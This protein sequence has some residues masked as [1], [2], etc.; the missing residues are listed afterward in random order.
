MLRSYSKTGESGPS[1]STPSMRTT[2]W[3]LSHPSTIENSSFAPT[4]S[5][6][7]SSSPVS[8]HTCRSPCH[9]QASSTAMS[10]G[11][12]IFLS[13]IDPSPLSPWSSPPL[14]R[15]PLRRNPL[16]RNPLRRNP[17]A[18]SRRSPSSAGSTTTRSPVS[19]APSPATSATK[20]RH[21]APR[22]LAIC[23][24]PRSNMIDRRSGAPAKN[25]TPAVALRG[26]PSSQRAARRGPRCEQ[27]LRV[28]TLQ[29][30]PRAFADRRPPRSSMGG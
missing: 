3:T 12:V 26:A 21:H 19:Q 11:S 28:K 6:P 4:N 18:S 10:P 9:S 16:R 13:S 24:P 20:V 25:V 30:S 17:L 29:R 22:R 23:A 14:R 8:V 15:N 7:D 27:S 5:G 1:G 2:L